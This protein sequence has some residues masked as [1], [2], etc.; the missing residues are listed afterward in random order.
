MFEK[1]LLNLCASNFCLTD[2][3]AIIN[4][5]YKN[6]KYAKLLHVLGLHEWLLSGSLM[7]HLTTCSIRK[8]PFCCEYFEHADEEE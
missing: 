4:V 2:A 8:I 6:V 5:S 1:L 3:E 7:I